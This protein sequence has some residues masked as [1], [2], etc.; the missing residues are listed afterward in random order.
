M[1]L[2]IKQLE[3]NYYNYKMVIYVKIYDQRISKEEA[4]QAFDA[5]FL[6]S[7]DTQWSTKSISFAIQAFDW[8]S[9]I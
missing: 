6:H 9:V 2:K 4:N 7:F 3:K 1:C 5:I 8:H